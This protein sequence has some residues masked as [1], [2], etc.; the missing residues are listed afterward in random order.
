MNISNFHIPDEPTLLKAKRIN[1]LYKFNHF[2]T[3]KLTGT[4][5]I[6]ILIDTSIRIEHFINNDDKLDLS[7][8]RC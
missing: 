4:Q 5:I 6:F 1:F 3:W 2:V 8:F 7:L